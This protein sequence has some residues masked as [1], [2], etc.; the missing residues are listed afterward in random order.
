[1]APGLAGFLTV[2]AG[3]FAPGPALPRFSAAQEQY[4]AHDRRRRR[5][6][7]AAEEKPWPVPGSSRGPFPAAG[8]RVAALLFLP[9]DRGSVPLLDRGPPLPAAGGGLLLAGAPRFHHG[10]EGLGFLPVVWGRRNLHDGLALRAPDPLAGEGRGN[11]HGGAAA[12]AFQGDFRHGGHLD[13]SAYCSPWLKGCQ[14]RW[15]T[16]ASLTHFHF[17]LR[18]HESIFR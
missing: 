3:V 10:H 17:P 9:P 13:T 4:R 16:T 14:L 12:V 18:R 11:R 8:G 5:R 1:L 15:R 7:Q 6:P 2:L